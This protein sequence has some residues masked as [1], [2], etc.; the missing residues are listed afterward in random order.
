MLFEQ[1]AEQYQ[2]IL[3]G[4]DSP[5]MGETRRSSFTQLMLGLMAFLIL[6]LTYT[7]WCYRMFRDTKGT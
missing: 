7:A 6:S 2:N 5:T 3:R 1:A 4:S